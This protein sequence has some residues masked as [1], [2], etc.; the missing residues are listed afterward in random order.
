MDTEEMVAQM[1]RTNTGRHMLDS[2]GAYGRH[3]ERNQERDFASEPE[4]T[5]EAYCHNG[6]AEILVTHNIYHWLNAAVTYDEEWD[7]KFHEFAEREEVS[8]LPWLR[9]AKAWPGH[10]Y[11][12]E[13]LTVAG[14]YG[15]GSGFTVNTYNGEDLLSQVLQYV[16]FEVA[17]ERYWYDDGFVVLQI[18]NGCD[19]RGGYTEPHVFRGGPDGDCPTIFDNARASIVPDMH[20]GDPVRTL[21]EAGLKYQFGWYTDDGYHWYSFNGEAH[22]L[23]EY[24]CT[25]DM[26]Q[27]GEGVIVVDEDRNAYCPV[28]GARLQS[29]YY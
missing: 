7:E 11:E 27:R 1:L 24:E 3:W 20:D 17:E 22:N 12:H 28:T 13:G 15:E 4:S 19:V 9:V 8:D 21:E 25:E 29:W 6:E 16:Y 18:H 5:I 26:T 23:N 2:G 10:L 14:I